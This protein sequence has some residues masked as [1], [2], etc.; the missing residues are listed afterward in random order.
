MHF[1]A[2]APLLL[3]YYRL[4]SRKVTTAAW[5]RRWASGRYGLQEFTVACTS[6]KIMIRGWNG[7]QIRIQSHKQ[8]YKHNICMLVIVAEVLYVA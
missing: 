4:G 2:P 5:Q 6:V 7:Y 1:E 8:P 3:L